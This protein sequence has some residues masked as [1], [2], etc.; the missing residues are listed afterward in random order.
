[1]QELPAG[2]AMAAVFTN[3][4]RVVAA[5]SGRNK[6]VSIAAVNG[7]DEVVISG[8][9]AVLEE[10]LSGIA[11]EGVSNRRIEVSHAFH[12]CRL[13]P[14]LD[15][16][17]A[18]ARKVKFSPPQITLVS[19]LTGR[20]FPAGAALDA[21]Y[22]RRHA[23][24]PVRFLECIESLRE[25]G[26]DVLV[27]VGPHPT[28]VNLAQRLAPESNWECL[29][30]LRKGRNC[31]QEMLSSLA[32]LY[33]NGAEIRWNAV[34]HDCDG[35]RISM[36]TYPFQ[37]ERYWLETKDVAPSRT[38]RSS[39]P[40][41]GERQER[42]DKSETFVWENLISLDSHSWLQDHCVQGS[43]IIPASAYAELGLAAGREALGGG[44]LSLKNIRFLK[45][46]VLQ[47]GVRRVLETTI[48]IVA[49][50]TAHLNVYSRVCKD[51]ASQHSR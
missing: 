2:G 50:H 47:D 29:A 17:E 46:M 39:H 12:S 33:V 36:P 49:Q 37:R 24:E 6:C 25:A 26:A 30:S 21:A 3:E 41:L 9:T 44:H 16:F 31:Y 28:L 45:P 35:R 22:W 43:V 48:E 51:Q 8:D 38:E 1:M 19:N 23:R 34:N 7:P 4:A 15:A 32:K 20:P 10:I 14:M 18:L 11:E 27:E 42:P 40:L 5:L 13:E